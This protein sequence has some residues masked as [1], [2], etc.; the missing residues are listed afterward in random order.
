MLCAQPSSMQPRVGRDELL[1][2]PSVGP[3]RVA[4]TRA[5]RPRT[6]CRYGSRTAARLRRRRPAHVQAVE[7]DDPAGVGRPPAER[8]VAVR[9]ASG[10]GRG[11]RPPAAFPA[12]GPRRSRRPRDHRPRPAPADPTTSAAARSDPSRA[13][14]PPP[15]VCSPGTATPWGPSIG[16]TRVQRAPIG[17][18]SGVSGAGRSVSPISQ[19]STAAAHDR[20]SAIAHTIRLWPRPMSPQTNTPST[21]VCQSLVRAPRCRAR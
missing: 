19:R 15:D 3:A 7:R 10:T 9:V 16:S 14:S 8:R 20:P 12:R 2:D 13:E 4:R 18:A 5:S 17:A 21:L 6:R 1:V 11:G